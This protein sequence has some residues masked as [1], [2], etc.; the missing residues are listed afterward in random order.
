MELSTPLGILTS[1]RLP[2]HSS[3]NQPAGVTAQQERPTGLWLVRVLAVGYGAS[4][5]DRDQPDNEETELLVT[6]QLHEGH[7]QRQHRPSE[8][9]DAGVKCPDSLPDYRKAEL[10]KGVDGTAQ[11]LVDT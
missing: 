8:A 1:G 2:D 6:V 7:G 5:R 9:H 4:E 3:G 10:H 11:G